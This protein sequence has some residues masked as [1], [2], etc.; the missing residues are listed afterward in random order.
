[1]SHL[2]PVQAIVH[3]VNAQLDTYIAS[4][5]GHK[6]KNAHSASLILYH[7]SKSQAPYVHSTDTGDPI[8]I[9]GSKNRVSS[10]QCS[11]AV[12]KLIKVLMRTA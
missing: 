8:Y 3:C 5:D 7:V 6:R 9:C 1:M 12:H 4:Q 10:W 11:Q 2:Y